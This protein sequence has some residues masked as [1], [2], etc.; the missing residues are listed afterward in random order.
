MYSLSLILENLGCE[1][2]LRGSADNFAIKFQSL[3]EADG[4]SVCWMRASGDEAIELIRRTKCNIL[5]CSEIEIS[6]EEVGSKTLIFVSNPHL[7]YLRLLSNFFGSK[8]KPKPGVHVSAI[9]S[10]DAKIGENVFIG[11]HV[12]LG[13]CTLGD[14][15][16]V[17]SYTIVH[18]GVIVGSNVL[19]SEHCNVGGE[20]FGYVRNEKNQLENMMHIG[21]LIIEDDVA[22]FPYT[23]IDR[24]TLGNTKIGSGSKIDHYCHIGHNSEIGSNNVITCNV[25]LLGGAKVGNNCFIGAGTMLRDGVR[26]GDNV[27]TGMASVITKNISDN[28][29]WVGSPARPADDFKNLQK[30]FS[31]ILKSKNIDEK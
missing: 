3:F 15:C 23:N 26:I 17:K 16:I 25:T 12:T 10:P 2:R 31:I 13:A 14:N 27:T 30:Q 4:E 28:E 8:L 20:G 22:I 29:V 24:G 5:I 7:A 19:I 21:G 9:I 1:Y 6:D 11:P 18:D